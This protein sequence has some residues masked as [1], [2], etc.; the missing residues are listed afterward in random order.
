MIPILLFWKFQTFIAFLWLCF[1]ISFAGICACCTLQMNLLFQILL[2]IIKYINKDW[3]ENK[4]VF[5]F[6]SSIWIYQ[7]FFLFSYVKELVSPSFVKPNVKIWNGQLCWHFSHSF[8]NPGQKW[9]GPSESWWNSVQDTCFTYPS[10]EFVLCLKN[11]S[12]SLI[13]QNIDTHLI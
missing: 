9:M 13:W 12:E 7:H 10:W 8:K 11:R 6:L 2:M 5:I 4:F 1:R 3:N